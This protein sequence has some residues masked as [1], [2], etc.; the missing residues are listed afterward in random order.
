MIHLL[1]RPRDEACRLV[2]LDYL[3][4]AVEARGRL[5]QDPEALH[6][7]RVAL[8][9]MRSTLRAYR[10]LLGRPLDERRRKQ[11]RQIVDATSISR[12]AEVLDAL[13]AEEAERLEPRERAG[14]EWL[15][16]R[17]AARKAEGDAQVD[18][19]LAHF[20]RIERRL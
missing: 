15:R 14:V 17:L 16:Q 13:V 5:G 1:E 19:R 9:R 3:D 18:K 12:D 4:E 2:A 8:R 11:L 6:D 7:L 10:Q 20:A